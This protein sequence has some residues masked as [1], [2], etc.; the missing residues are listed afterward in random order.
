M[1]IAIKLLIFGS[2]VCAI[3]GCVVA[4]A[5]RPA[6]AYVAVSAPYT[7]VGP[8]NYCGPR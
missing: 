5:D 1:K 7:V 8:H 6:R 3:G 4:P 2:F